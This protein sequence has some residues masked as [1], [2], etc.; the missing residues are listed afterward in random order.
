MKE[1]LRMFTR[2]HRREAPLIE[3]IKTISRIAES[4]LDGDR[5]DRS[6]DYRALVQIKDCSKKALGVA[7]NLPPDEVPISHGPKDLT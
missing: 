5:E 3:A 4:R 7:T 2:F 6:N 1:R